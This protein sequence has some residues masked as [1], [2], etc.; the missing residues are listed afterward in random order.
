MKQ[1]KQI[2]HHLWWLKKFLEDD[3]GKKEYKEVIY[4]DLS[5]DTIKELDEL[6]AH[7]KLNY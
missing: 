4:K 5:D 7:I 6:V 1:D 3:F 2:I